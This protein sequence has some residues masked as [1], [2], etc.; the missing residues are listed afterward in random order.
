MAASNVHPYNNSAIEFF[1]N[2]CCLWNSIIQKH[3]H[4]FYVF[5]LYM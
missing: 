5:D 2:K 4:S 3:C 1:K